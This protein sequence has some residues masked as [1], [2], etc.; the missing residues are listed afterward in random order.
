MPQL[1]LPPQP[2]RPLSLLNPLRLLRLLPPKWRHLRRKPLLLL[3][4]KPLLLLRQLLRLRCSLARLR[5]LRL[6]S[7]NPQ[8]LSLNP[9]RQRPRHQPRQSLPPLRLRHR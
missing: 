2:G 7:L 6:P 8:R 1:S 9:P 5:K 4:R 3:R